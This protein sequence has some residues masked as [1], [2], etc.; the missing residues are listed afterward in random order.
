MKEKSKMASASQKSTIFSAAVLTSQQP[1]L[2]MPQPPLLTLAQDVLKDN[3]RQFI[4]D[5]G[6]IIDKKFEEKNAEMRKDLLFAL[7][8]LACH[9]E[10]VD[11]GEEEVEEYVESLEFELEMEEK[12]DLIQNEVVMPQHKEL[13]H[14]LIIRENSRE[15]LEEEDAADLV[16]ILNCQPEDI[17][18]EMEKNYRINLRVA[19]QKNLPRDVVIYSSRKSICNGIIQLFY[20]QKIPFKVFRRR[21]DFAL[22]SDKIP[23]RKEFMKIKRLK[24]LYYYQV[25]QNHKIKMKL[26]NK[27]ETIRKLKE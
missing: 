11:G 21:K 27:L 10:C 13:E 25:R 22:W 14:A 7:Q 24:E 26:S 1:K 12:V 2:D 3:I 17:M 15:K 4:M 6:K 18:R 23:G 8:G 5:M 16:M 19:R 20:K 9:E